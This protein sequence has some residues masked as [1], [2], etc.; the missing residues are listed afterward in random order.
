MRT[1]LAPIL[2]LIGTAIAL[3][4][5]PAN[6]PVLTPI[7]CDNTTDFNCIQ[8]TRPLNNFGQG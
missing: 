3:Y 7:C 8:V 5:C 1:F 2:A 4:E 6:D